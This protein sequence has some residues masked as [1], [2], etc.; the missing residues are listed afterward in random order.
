MPQMKFEKFNNKDKTMKARKI[1]KDG[2][3]AVV[4]FTTD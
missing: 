4:I 1:L 3:T 2:E